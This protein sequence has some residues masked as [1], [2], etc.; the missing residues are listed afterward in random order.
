MD[1]RTPSNDPLTLPTEN[2]GRLAWQVPLGDDLAGLE[3]VIE[4]SYELINW[5]S[6]PL[7]VPTNNGGFLSTQETQANASTRKFVRLRPEIPALLP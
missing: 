4:I 1:W 2:A 7:D 3:P 6:A 5:N